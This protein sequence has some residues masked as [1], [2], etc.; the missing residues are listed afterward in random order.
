MRRNVYVT[1]TLTQVKI[2]EDECG[3]I[4]PHYCRLRTAVDS[5]P[6]GSS[7]REPRNRRR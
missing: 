7:G 5:D 4:F 2:G 3:K 1:L 6:A